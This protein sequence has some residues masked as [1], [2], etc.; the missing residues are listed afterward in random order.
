MRIHRP[1]LLKEAVALLNCR[2]GG[3]YVDCTAGMAGHSQEILNASAPDGR[4]LAMDR[5]EQAIEIVRQ[6]LATFGN[7]VITV[8]SDFREI[9]TILEEQEMQEANGILADLGASML[10]FTDP[11]RGFSF[12]QEGPLDMRMDRSQRET[13]EDLVNRLSEADLKKVLKE[14]GEETAAGKIAKRII[15]ERKNKPFRTTTQL[16][17]LIEKVVPARRGQK[18]HPATRTFQALRIAVNHELEGLGEFLFDAFDVLASEGRLVIISFH[19]LEDRIVKH[20]FRFLS[21]AC[22]CS[23]ALPICRCG[24]KPLSK[25][26]T[27]SPATASEEEVNENPASRSAKMR[28]IEKIEGSAPRELWGPWLREHE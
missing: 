16:S 21:A 22:R 27:S 3:L 28:A 13:A 4:L 7:R 25:L 15:Q 23:K 11:Q 19:S 1:V 24:G 17:E 9:R 14:F 10:Q 26:L 18:I 20:V 5:D 12:Q 2:S 6:K 8:H